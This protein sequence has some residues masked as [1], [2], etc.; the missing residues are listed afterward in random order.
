MSITN[1]KKLNIEQGTDEWHKE[2]NS[3]LCG[4]SDAPAIFGKSKYVSRSEF[5][6]QK[7]GHKKNVS[8]YTKNI[9]ENG[10]IVE[11]NARQLLEIRFAEDIKPSVYTCELEGI[12]IGASLDGVIDSKKMIFE[13]KQWNQELAENVRKGVLEESHSLQLDLQMLVSGYKKTLFV[14][15]DGTNLKWVEMIYET[16]Q[17]KLDR[18]INGIKQAYED[19]KSYKIKPIKEKIEVKDLEFPI[20]EC[21]ANVS[22]G[23]YQIKENFNEY[24][25]ALNEISNQVFKII[26]KKEKTELDF[27]KLEQYSKEGKQARKVIKSKLDAVKK[28]FK[29]YMQFE[30]NILKFDSVI[31]KFSAAAEKET[32]LAKDKIKQD[33][34]LNSIKDL[35]ILNFKLNERW[36]YLNYPFLKEESINNIKQSGKG[37]KNI[38]TFRESVESEAARIKIEMNQC[39]DLV[40]IFYRYLYV[41]S[42]YDYL[43]ND[44]LTLIENYINDFDGFK[45]IIKERI[46]E[47]K[48]KESS[49]KHVY[50]DATSTIRHKT[51]VDYDNGYFNMVFDG[52]VIETRI[53]SGMSLGEIMYK[54][55]LLTHKL[56]TFH[57]ESY[58]N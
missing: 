26:E 4:A 37:K 34:I 38:D 48:E 8:E 14:V 41:N 3:W 31:Q 2:R 27:A 11:E 52:F 55:E 57:N 5:F 51:I 35:E 12:K 25:I 32:K 16:T 50:N 17:E 10:H 28:V 23:A 19:L 29:D 13:C 36:S 21:Y 47:H 39:F 20:I 43:F 9:F 30:S 49:K 42:E 58:E 24:S 7:L 6:E 18:M 22:P 40:K 54:L 45:K 53:C 46:E 33:I 1:K 56:K 15:T 44:K